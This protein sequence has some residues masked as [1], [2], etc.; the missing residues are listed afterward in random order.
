MDLVVASV[1]EA[2]RWQQE[3]RRSRPAWPPAVSQSL[4][5]DSQPD[6]IDKDSLGRKA[7][8]VTSRTWHLCI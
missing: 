6:G 5:R 2:V 1:V 7:V 8:A 3:S 4:R